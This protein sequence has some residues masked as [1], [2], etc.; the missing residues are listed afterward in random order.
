MTNAHDATAKST[1]C[2]RALRALRALADGRYGDWHGLDASCTTADATSTLGA[3]GVDQ[4]GSLGGS[5]TRYRIHPAS[6]G[7]PHG[8]YVYDVSDKLVHVSTHGA[9]PARP[10]AEQLGEPEARDI[11]RMP[12]FKTQW[13]WASRGLTLHID[14]GTGAVAWLYAYRP[15]TLDEFRASWISKVEI[16]RTRVE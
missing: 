1:N 9:V 7:A 3:G 11:S 14:D 12:G 13:I 4:T 10:P 5:P 6:V 2:A 15:M 8:L 16:R